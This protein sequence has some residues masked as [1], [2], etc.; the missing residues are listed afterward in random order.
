MKKEIYLEG[1]EIKILGRFRNKTSAKSNIP[2]LK[3]NKQ[4]K[5]EIKKVLIEI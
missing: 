5:L 2:K 3:L 4:E 1:L